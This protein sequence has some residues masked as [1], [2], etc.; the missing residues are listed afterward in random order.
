ME[1]AK[2]LEIRPNKTEIVFIALESIILASQ[3]QLK[4]NSIIFNRLSCTIKYCFQKDSLLDCLHVK[5]RCK[6]S[7][8][9]PYSGENTLM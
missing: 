4:P 7:R 5:G 8:I 3:T 1:K 2:R 9:A 6:C